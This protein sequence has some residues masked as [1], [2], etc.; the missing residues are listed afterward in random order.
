MQH[1][2]PGLNRVVACNQKAHHV[3]QMQCRQEHE[4]D[5]LRLPSQ[6]RA[7]IGHLAQILQ[8]RLQVR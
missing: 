8:L 6:R 7:A 2:A 1:A 5:V 3:D 4:E